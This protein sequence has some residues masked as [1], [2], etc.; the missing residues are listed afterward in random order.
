MNEI[1]ILKNRA[2]CMNKVNTY[3]Y[4]TAKEIQTDMIKNGFK[5]NNNY[6]FHKKTK[7]KL[8][9]IQDK[10]KPFRAVLYSKEYSIYLWSDATYI[11]K[12]YEANNCGVNYYKKSVY[13]WD[14]IK[15]EPYKIVK[16]KK[17]TVE[18]LQKAEI[19]LKKLKNDVREK[20]YAISKLEN[21][22]V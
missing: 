19:K 21:L 5:T 20:Q 18:Q 16:P 14:V 11:V 8:K 15:N 9:A 13:I 2:E 1:N 4:K 10:R 12:R 6:S 7:D 17:I 3:L 22:F